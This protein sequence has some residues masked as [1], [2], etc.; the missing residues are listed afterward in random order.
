MNISKSYITNKIASNSSISKKQSAE[1]LDTFLALIK[2]QIKSNEVKLSGFGT[3]NIKKSS[4]RIGRNPKTLESYIISP[5]DVIRFKPSNKIKNMF[6]KWK[7]YT[8]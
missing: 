5:A 8:S 7:K 2:T 1:I 4:E 3:F 6:N